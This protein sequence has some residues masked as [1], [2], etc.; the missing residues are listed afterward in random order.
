MV[1]G[2]L[3]GA[4]ANRQVCPTISEMTFG[5]QSNKSRGD[6]KMIEKEVLE[7]IRDPRRV[8]LLADEFRQGRDVGDLLPLLDSDNEEM[9]G[10][11]AWIAGEVKIDPATAQPLVSRLHQLVNHENPLIRVHAIGA[12]FPFFDIWNPASREM[13]VRLSDDPNEGVRMIAQAA[14]KILTQE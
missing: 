9:V 1:G 5:N 12:L 7:I 13:L 10:I 6:K 2:A 8:N 3:L 14:L 4:A 11:G